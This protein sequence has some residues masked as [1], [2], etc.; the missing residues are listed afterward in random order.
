M[1][2]IG[3]HPRLISEDYDELGQIGA[4]TSA[5]VLALPVQKYLLDF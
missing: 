2:F 1:E 3:A 5:K 4:I